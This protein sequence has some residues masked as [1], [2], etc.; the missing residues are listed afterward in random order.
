MGPRI[1]RPEANWRVVVAL[2]L[3][4]G[5]GL[6]ASA[7]A[8]TIIY[9]DAAS[10][11]SVRDGTS[12]ARAYRCLPD[13]LAAAEGVAE[14]QIWVRAGIYHP[15]DSDEGLVSEG[16]RTV[17]FVLRD[18]VD[19]YGGFAGNETPA[20][21]DLRNPHRNV[22]TLSG[23]LND[24]D[25][26]AQGT[27]ENSYHVVYANQQVTDAVLDGF[28]ITAGNA[29]G[30]GQDQDQGAGLFLDGATLTVRNCTID[31]ND[32]DDNGGGVYRDGGSPTFINCKFTGNTA[33]QNGGAFYGTGTG[34]A[35]L[36][37]CTCVNNTATSG[38]AG[39][40]YSGGGTPAISNSIFWITPIKV[41]RTIRAHRFILA[42]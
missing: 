16:D 27:A 9:V 11:G 37:N 20:D 41:V 21:F 10:V 25:N 4:T 29:G 42:L 40:L 8:K 15:D 34:T 17:S 32:A 38:T 19:V 30:V 28:V 1:G 13:A 39:G 22:T 12:W 7:D 36:I 18:E 35:S 31:A 26:G 2:M 33:A 14:V 6:P 5:L 3:V 23:D 24:D